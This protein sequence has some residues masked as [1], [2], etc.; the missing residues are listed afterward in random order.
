MSQVKFD[1]HILMIFY[2]KWK[3]YRW[4]NLSEANVTIFT[5]TKFLELSKI[6]KFGA[7]KPFYFCIHWKN[8]SP[9]FIEESTELIECVS[10]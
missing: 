4:Q 6:Y 3:M 9:L 5:E 10:F 7:F 2:Q 1:T 8:L